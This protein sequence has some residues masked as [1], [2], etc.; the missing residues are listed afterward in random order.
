MN[1]IVKLC[2]KTDVIALFT[3]RNHYKHDTI[4][5]LNAIKKSKKTLNDSI[6][7]GEN[8]YS[9]DTFGVFMRN[10]KQ[11]T[12]KI[13]GYDVIALNNINPGTELTYDQTLHEKEQTKN[14]VERFF[15]DLKR[16]KY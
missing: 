14:N 11:P 10:S 7:I 15:D 12:C 3:T 13:I 4:F 16:K 5:R 6:Y 1:I 9:F 2:K 8:K